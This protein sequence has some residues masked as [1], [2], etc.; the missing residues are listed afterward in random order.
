MTGRI[1]LALAVAGALAILYAKKTGATEQPPP[2]SWV[3][4]EVATG[5]PWVSPKG[6]QVTAS[7]PVAC[8][9]AISEA[10]KVAAAG[11]RLSCRK[12]AR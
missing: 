8:D 12:V 7:N 6:H 11:T 10:T 1:G 3:V 9:L 2:R 4:V 5:Q